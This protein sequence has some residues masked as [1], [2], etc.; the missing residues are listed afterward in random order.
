MPKEMT[1][2]PKVSIVIPT[3][4]RLEF[5]RAAIT[6]AICQRYAPLEIIVSDN[7]SDDGSFGKLQQEFRDAE[8]VTFI[9]N[10]KNVGPTLNWLAAASIA[11]GDYIKVL[12]SD[13]LLDPN[14]IYELVRCFDEESGFVISKCQIG[15]RPWEGK[16]FYC[17][18]WLL[19]ISGG[20]RIRSWCAEVIYSIRVGR[21]G[22]LAM[23][24]SP[25]AGM[26]RRKDFQRWLENSV[27]RPCSRYALDTGAGPDIELYFQA[28]RE[29]RFFSF[30]NKRLV[31]FRAHK[32]SLTVG[33]T[34]H[35]VR[36]SY[37]SAFKRFVQ[38]R[39]ITLR[40][41]SRIRNLALG[42]RR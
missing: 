8:N 30:T 36:D 12:F 3:Y 20:N 10:A 26:F 9:Q 35:E 4:K 14:T 31:Y 42:R 21:L 17:I 27:D 32:G 39:G 6:S 41:I 28:L 37:D 16:D 33:Q 25:A 22:W 1:G 34:K 40:I 5:T 19:R 7:A 18:N 29:Y 38:D 13:D 23:P 15:S 2:R 24:S 11:D